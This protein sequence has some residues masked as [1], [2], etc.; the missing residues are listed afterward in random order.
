MWLEFRQREE[1]VQLLVRDDGVGF[2]LAMVRAK[3]A[4]GASFGVLG[5]QERAELLGGQLSIES[6]PG[7]GTTISV[8]FL[9]TFQTIWRRDRTRRQ[10]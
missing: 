2:D 9:M 4:L 5:M 3:A 10:P 6:K 8:R 7:C 1:E